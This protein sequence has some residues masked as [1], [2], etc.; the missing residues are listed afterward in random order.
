METLLILSSFCI[1]SWMSPSVVA[2]VS[3]GKYIV[4][5]NFLFIIFVLVEIIAAAAVDSDFSYRFFR[6]LRCLSD[7]CLSQS[8]T[9]LKMFDGST[10]HLAGTPVDSSDT[11]CRIGISLPLRALTVT[12]NPQPKHAIAYDLPAGSIDQRCRL[13]AN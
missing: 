7:C 8:F 4:S 5:V 1:I 11:L 13:L 6:S 3:E 12:L 10:C 2:V 9:M